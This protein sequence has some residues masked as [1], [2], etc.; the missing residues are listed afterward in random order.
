MRLDT[1]APVY[2]L[3]KV[4]YMQIRNG[5]MLKTQ[6]PTQ[7]KMKR[8]QRKESMGNTMGY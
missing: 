8:G 4:K 3:K 5:H 7:H 2:F 1:D 6:P